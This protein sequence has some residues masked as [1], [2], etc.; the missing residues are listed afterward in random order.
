MVTSERRIEINQL[1]DSVAECGN[2]TAVDFHRWR[3]AT[4]SARTDGV[5]HRQHGV[6]YVLPGNLRAPIAPEGCA[7][8]LE[9]GIETVTLLIVE[10]RLWHT[11]DRDLLERVAAGLRH[12]NCP[13][14]CDCTEPVRGRA[15]AIHL[16]A[17]H[18]GHDCP[19]F[20]LA[21]QYIED[22]Q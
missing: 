10:I 8:I 18:A 5:V 16:M 1:T 4:E 3:R 14:A 22:R 20:R 17:D 6:A 11:R 9:C 7:E 21:A 19:R 15:H 12:L 13:V 2:V